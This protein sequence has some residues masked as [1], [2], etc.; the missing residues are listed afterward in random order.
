[1]RLLRLQLTPRLIRD[2]PARHPLRLGVAQPHPFRCTVGSRFC[3]AL[4]QPHPWIVSKG[5]SPSGVSPC[6]CHQSCAPSLG[7]AASCTPARASLRDSASPR[8][9]CLR[10]CEWIVDVM[11]IPSRFMHQADAARCRVSQWSVS[12][13]CDSKAR[14]SHACLR[15]C[16]VFASAR[17]TKRASR[18]ARD[19]A[20]NAERR[21][22][23]ELR[24]PER[25][26]GRQG[27]GQQ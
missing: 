25:Y 17:Q 15:L 4:L 2:A 23:R 24:R 3:S 18:E 8:G 12:Q 20:R 6:G 1:M 7:E 27:T 5:V 11:Y 16:A 26:R 21:T 9:I 19:K 14:P 10:S 22:T 13:R